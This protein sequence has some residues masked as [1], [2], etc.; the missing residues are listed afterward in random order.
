MQHCDSHILWNRAAEKVSCVQL[1]PRVKGSIQLMHTCR[2][3][4]TILLKTSSTWFLLCLKILLKWLLF[5][6]KINSHKSP[7]NWKHLQTTK[8]NICKV[9]ISVSLAHFRIKSIDYILSW[10]AGSK[11]HRFRPAGFMLLVVRSFYKAFK[12]FCQHRVALGN[13]LWFSFLMLIHHRVRFFL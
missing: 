4:R 12:T 6:S 10:L 1:G 3:H 8:L 5:D 7:R 9:S 11:M 13:M 2:K